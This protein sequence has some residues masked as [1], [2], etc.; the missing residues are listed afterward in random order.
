M[1]LLQRYWNAPLQI[2]ANIGVAHAE[3]AQN[4]GKARH[5]HI[6][7][8]GQASDTGR[9]EGARSAAGYQRKAPRVEPLFDADVLKGALAGW[10]SEGG[11]LTPMVV[12]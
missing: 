7:T 6:L 4:A 10:E 2:I 8:A 3:R 11:A 9:M 12:A 5:E 1:L